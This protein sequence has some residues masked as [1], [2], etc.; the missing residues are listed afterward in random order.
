[1]SKLIAYL[2]ALLRRLEHYSV[3]DVDSHLKPLTRIH[4]K[5]VATERAANAAAERAYSEVVA[6]RG[7]GRAHLKRGD[8]AFEAAAKIGSLIGR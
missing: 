1:M 4:D 3:G 5:L 2:T 8:D 7:H 6:L